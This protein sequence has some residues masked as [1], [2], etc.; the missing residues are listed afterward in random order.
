M[1][2][3]DGQTGEVHVAPFRDEANETVQFLMTYRTRLEENHWQGEQR[4]KQSEKELK[5]SEQ[6]LSLIYNATNDYMALIKVEYPETFRLVSFNEAYWRATKQ[7]FG[8]VSEEQLIDLTI[9]EYGNFLNWPD[10]SV[11]ETIGHYSAAIK[12]GKPLSVVDVLPA[13]DG[14]LYLENRYCPVFDDKNICSHILFISHDITDRK[15]AEKENLKLE[16]QVQQAQKLESLGVLA[17][18]IAHDF[19][20]LLVGVLGNADLALMSMPPES[21]GRESI[22][23]IEIAAERAADLA[24]QM[25]AYSG[26]GQFVIKCMDLQALVEEMV[27]LLET[28]ISKKAAIRCD[29]A[30]DVPTV[31]ADATQMRQIIMNLVINASEAIEDRSGVISISTGTKECN[32]GYLS[33]A[34]SEKELPEGTYSYFQITDTGSGMDEETVGR[35]FDPFFTTKFTG[36]GLGLA[37]VLGIVRSHK[38]AIKVYSEPGKGT[39][40]KILLPAKEG[41]LDSLETQS[42]HMIDTKLEGKTALLVDDEETVRTVGTQM[43]ERLGL[44]VTTAIDGREALKIFKE[45]PGKFNYIILDLAMP[46]MD[47]EETFREMRRIRKEIVV[48]LSSGYA[49]QD[50]ISR[51]TEKGFAGFIQKPYRIVNLKEKLLF[52]TN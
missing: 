24:K 50:L 41:T 36:R 7:N 16:R 17:G 15:R 26:K 39:T 11:K 2:G 10:S 3:V 21:P 20:N 31:E 40:F 9:E 22:H 19:N 46:H 29:F 37:A 27:H 28:V 49:E 12:T 5:E 42:D 33:G 44:S 45:D 13:P 52:V 8:D 32:Q 35:I 25:L 43:L 1:G 34:Y 4:I 6:R 18:G 38:G 30:Q 47:G 14:E 48:I 23:D 51:F